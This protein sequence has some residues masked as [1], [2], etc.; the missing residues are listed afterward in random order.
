LLFIAGVIVLGSAFAGGTALFASVA[1]GMTF[2]AAF[3]KTLIFFGIGLAVIGVICFVSY[4]Y[5]KGE[6]ITQAEHKKESEHNG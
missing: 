3:I 5:E 1:F 6:E 4:I 2:M